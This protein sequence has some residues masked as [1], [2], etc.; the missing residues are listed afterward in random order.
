MTDVVV[1]GAGAIGLAS[2]LA[3][4]RRGASVCVLERTS[5]GAGA[6]ST[7]AGVL[8]M[9]MECRADGPLGRLSIASLKMYRGWVEDLVAQTGIDVGMR[10]CGGMNVAFE[11]SDVDAVEAW[12]AW[13]SQLGFGTERLDA[14]SALALE[15]ALSPGIAGA[16]RFPAEARI[17]PPLLMKALSIA[18]ARAGVVVRSGALVRRVAV[19]GGRVSGVLLEEGTLVAAR[20]VVLAA[21][22]W[23]TLVEGTP[24]LPDAVRPARGQI[25]ELVADAP[26]VKH[27]VYGPGCYL[28]PRDDGRVLI[29]STIEFVGF[30][31][32]VPA[33]AVQALLAAAIRVVPALADV[34]LSRAWSCFRPATPDE[35]PM[36]GPT[37]VD[38]LHVATGHFRN[39]IVLTPITAAIIA[40]AVS[41]EPAPAGLDVAPFS[42]MRATRG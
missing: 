36:I 4:A 18:A 30:R 8:G 19:E 3:L 6:S 9:Q 28:S 11:P 17:D 20:S 14:S 24:L 41:G 29:G 22:S 26:P 33:G 42:A 23:S 1:I 38:G 31:P 34:S 12:A 25:V 35:L 10:A 40:A 32:G 39:G 7:A 2:A 5:P 37:A 16:V 21:G 15:P 13:P 27:I